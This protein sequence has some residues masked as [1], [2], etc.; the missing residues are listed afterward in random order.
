[1]IHRYQYIDLVALFLSNVFKM[2]G[3]VQIIMPLHARKP[4]PKPW[5][6]HTRGSD[7]ERSPKISALKKNRV[8][9]M[10]GKCR[11]KKPES[12]LFVDSF[13]SSSG[14]NRVHEKWGLS[15]A[16]PPHVWDFFFSE[17]KIVGLLSLSRPL[18]CWSQ[19]FR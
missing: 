11:Q 13:F 5:L 2:F 6:Q 17:L 9:D 7:R 15:T 10:E 4:Y 16:F 3:L 18:V 12:P 8:P 19:G 14:K 1:M